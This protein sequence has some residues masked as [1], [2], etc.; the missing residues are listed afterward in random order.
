VSALTLDAM[1]AL[2]GSLLRLL[3]SPAN[4]RDIALENLT[5][6][7]QLAVMKR[8][9]PRPRLRTADRLFWAWLSRIWPNWRN[10]LLLVRPETVLSWHRQGFCLFWAWIR[11]G[12]EPVAPV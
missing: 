8:Q 5:L 10:A 6:S 1:F 4:L 2:L 7:Q 9:S 11:G 3:L 12:S